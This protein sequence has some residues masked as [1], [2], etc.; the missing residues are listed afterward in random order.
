MFSIRPNIFLHKEIMKQDF[1]CLK[2][3]TDYLCKEK[4]KSRKIIIYCRY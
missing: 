1:D 2:W 4:D 3:I